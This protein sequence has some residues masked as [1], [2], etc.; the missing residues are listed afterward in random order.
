M[1]GASGCHH[2]KRPG[3][4]TGHCLEKVEQGK[5]AKVIGKIEKSFPGVILKTHTGGKELSKNLKT[6]YYQESA[7]K[8]AT[9][10]A[11]LQV[12]L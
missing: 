11:I 12:H 7:S 3:R 4:K 1:R 10:I 5:G 6:V 2:R 9:F 8:I